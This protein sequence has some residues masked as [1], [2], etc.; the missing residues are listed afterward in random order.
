MASRSSGGGGSI[1]G[2]A[3]PYRS[4]EGLS[5]RPMA[6]SDEIQLRI[7]PIH[8]DLDDEITGLRSQV[9]QLRNVA[10][11]IESEAKYQKDFL[12]T[13]SGKGKKSLRSNRVEVTDKPGHRSLD[14]LAELPSMCS[15]PPFTC[16]LANM[17][18]TAAAFL[19]DLEPLLISS[20]GLVTS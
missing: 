15:P 1:Y 4:R 6:S 7:D 9:R 11:E 20:V 10:Q 17:R 12:E 2:G 14:L 18:I 8:G 19:N 16:S 5:T 13:L 3:A